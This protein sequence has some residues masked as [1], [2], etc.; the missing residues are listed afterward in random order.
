MLSPRDKS[1]LFRKFVSDPLSFS[2]K[3]L[4]LYVQNARLDPRVA[5]AVTEHIRDFWWKYRA[6]TLN[7]KL[8]RQPWPQAIKPMINQIIEFCDGDE[9]TAKEFKAWSRGVIRGFGN[10]PPQLYFV[11]HVWPRSKSFDREFVDSLPSFSRCGYFA[12]DL[13]FNKG[14]ARSIKGP[15]LNQAPA[16]DIEIKLK[17]QLIKDIQGYLA[18]FSTSQIMSKTGIDRTTL[19]K[20]RLGRL[21]Q[22]SLKR[23]ARFSEVLA[24]AYEDG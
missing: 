20:I 7:K 11:P 24:K 22:L 9:I 19:S 21:N 4:A 13:L 23:L 3:D 16:L 12:K 6:E 8:L 2:E 17:L 5:E 18:H 15:P 1:K 10:S 14:K